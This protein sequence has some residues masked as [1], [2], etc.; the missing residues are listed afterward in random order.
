ML[1]Q[2]HIQA[3][4][5]TEVIELKVTRK[6]LFVWVVGDSVCFIFFVFNLFTSVLHRSRSWHLFSNFSR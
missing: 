6:L 2:Q 3:G 1:Q 5:K 4:I